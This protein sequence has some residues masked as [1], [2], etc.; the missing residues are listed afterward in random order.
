ME[1]IFS[2]SLRKHIDAT[3]K[4][5]ISRAVIIEDGVSLNGVPKPYVTIE[6][7]QEVSEIIA[8]GRRSYEEVHAYQIGV[9]GTSGQNLGN[10]SAKLKE[11]L[12]NPDGIPIYNIATGQPT[13]QT[14]VIDVGEYT[15]MRASDTAEESFEHRG[16]FVVEINILRNAGEF[17]FTQ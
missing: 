11:I 13:D 3:L 14:F 17:T 9:F 2:Y 5:D 6:Y 12:R 4:P 8:S 1:T 7:I 15:P 16:Y 10:T